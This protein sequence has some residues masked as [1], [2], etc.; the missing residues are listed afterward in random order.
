MTAVI[1]GLT[2]LA[3]GLGLPPPHMETAPPRVQPA[4]QAQTEARPAPRLVGRASR[5]AYVRGGAAA[6]PQLRAWLGPDWRGQKVSVC[7]GTD[8]VSV[9]L[10]D[11]CQCYKG[12]R[13]ERVIDL[14]D[15]SFAALAPLWKGVVRVTIRREQ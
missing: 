4:A 13:K 5:Y 1:V 3:S 8:C 15:R 9:T 12:E 7:I 2:L 11:W 6:G 14:D 10:S